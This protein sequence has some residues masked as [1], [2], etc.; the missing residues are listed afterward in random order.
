MR[1]YRRRRDP[2]KR[3]ITNEA[4]QINLQRLQNVSRGCGMK[5]TCTKRGKFVTSEASAS[6]PAAA[7]PEVSVS[8]CPGCRRHQKQ[9]FTAC[10]L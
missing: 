5:P 3:R 1:W 2:Q 6:L 9:L 10:L 7:L 4:A 8:W